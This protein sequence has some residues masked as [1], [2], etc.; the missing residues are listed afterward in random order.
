[1]DQNFFNPDQ[2]KK[3]STGNLDFYFIVQ[4]VTL[5]PGT[6]APFAGF[7]RVG[8]TQL[9]FEFNGGFCPK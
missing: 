6:I 8:L 7:T 4:L 3:L 1:M 2:A 5:V 9:G